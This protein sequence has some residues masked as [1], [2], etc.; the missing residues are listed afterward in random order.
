MKKNQQLM[1]I[2]TV[3]TFTPSADVGVYDSLVEIV[4]TAEDFVGGVERTMA[5]DSSGAM[6]LRRE[7][8][9]ENSWSARME[10]VR[11]I[12]SDFDPRQAST[13]GRR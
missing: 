12:L 10:Q 7:I 9:R 2:S 3:Y 13:C 5:N 4:G 8:A 11:Q 6:R 1:V